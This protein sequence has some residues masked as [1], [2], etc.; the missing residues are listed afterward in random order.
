MTKWVLSEY[1]MME[2][3]AER[4]AALA[5]V[6]ELEAA[7]PRAYER[8]RGDAAKALANIFPRPAPE[9]QTWTICPNTLVFIRDNAGEWAEDAYLETVEAI[10]LSIQ[11]LS[12]ISAI[13]PPADLG[14]EVE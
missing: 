7:I 12:S 10:A 14:K 1:E 4:D 9:N 5:R 3:Q 2:L 13:T 11:R 8:G 6:A